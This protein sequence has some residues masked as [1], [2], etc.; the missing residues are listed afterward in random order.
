MKGFSSLISYS[1]KEAYINGEVWVLDICLA[2]GQKVLTDDYRVT[3]F[4]PDSA[5]YSLLT[6]NMAIFVL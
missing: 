6:R 1:I 4:Y 2:F 3:N 5:D